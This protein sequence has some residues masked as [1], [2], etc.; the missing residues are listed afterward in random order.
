[1][2]IDAGGA[3]LGIGMP[4]YQLAP[5]DLADLVAYLQVLGTESDPGVSPERIRLGT[6]LPPESAAPGLRAAMTRTLDAFARDL[7]ERGGV[8]RRAVEI[9]YDDLAASSDEAGARVARFL[10]ERKVFAL[11][12]PYVAGRGTPIFQATR[13]AGVPVVGIVGDDDEEGLSADRHVF[14]TLPGLVAQAR[15]LAAFATQSPGLLAPAIVGEGH[16]ASIRADAAVAEAWARAGLTAPERVVVDASTDDRDLD[17]LVRR[18]ATR[19]G[20]GVVYLGPAALLRPLID[21]AGRASW[22]PRLFVPISLGGG[23]LSDLPPAF[24][25][26][27]VLAFP[28]LPDDVTS[29]GQALLTRLRDAHDLPRDHQAT[30]LALLTALK[31]VEEGLRRAGR[32]LSRG[33]LIEE[34]EHLESFETGLSRPLTFGPNRHLGV[35]GAYLVTIR[36]GGRRLD[37]EGWIE[38]DTS[39]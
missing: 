30:Q 14:R 7:N 9:V 29:A 5:R 20:D 33:R 32:D 25:G 8:Y 39:P 21:A 10:D 12:T 26:R 15:A 18:L 27:I 22:H 17:R 38:V 35:S 36:D 37:P 31:V 11:V 28:Y 2:G 3:R 23:V 13:E 1:M 6:L 34:L 4:R 16:P 19:G 24:D